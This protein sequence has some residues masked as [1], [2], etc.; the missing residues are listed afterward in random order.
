MALVLCTGVNAELMRSRRI[1]LEAAGH[2]VIGVTD[3]HEL[4]TACEAHQFAVAVLGEAISRRMKRA[5]G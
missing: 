2:T 5:L 1:V 4:E 3:L